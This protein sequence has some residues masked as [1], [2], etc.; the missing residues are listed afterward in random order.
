MKNGSGNNIPATGIHVTPK[1]TKKYTS[2]KS[3][4]VAMYL[5]GTDSTYEAWAP[6]R[7]LPKTN[8]TK[9]LAQMIIICEV[10]TY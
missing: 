1:Q 2:W 10:Y 3:V 4:K 5:N 9:E 7:T 6:S 8:A